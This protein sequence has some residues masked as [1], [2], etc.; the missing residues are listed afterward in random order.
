MYLPIY[1]FPHIFL[2]TALQMTMY[3]HTHSLLPVLCRIFISAHTFVT[4]L[5]LIFS[6]WYN[7]L[8]PGGPGLAGTRISPFISFLALLELRMM[9]VVVTTA[10][11]IR[12]KLQSQSPPT[13]NHPS[14]FTDQMPF[15][16]LNQ[17]C[18]STKGNLQRILDNSNNSK[19]IP[20]SRIHCVH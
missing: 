10:A 3:S 13:N 19:F 8:F 6:L 7:G 12:A 14:Y 5:R 17:Q 2:S 4:I 1:D 9:E 15:L 18:Q 20:C 11:I 16:S